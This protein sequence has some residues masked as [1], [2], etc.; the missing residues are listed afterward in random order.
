LFPQGAQTALAVR[1]LT[2]SKESVT[3]GRS[4][5]RGPDLTAP[6][7]ESLPEAWLRES[8]KARTVT[9]AKGPKIN[10]EKDTFAARLSFMKGAGP[11]MVKSRTIRRRR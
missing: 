11:A 9:P 10:R 1:Q 4:A 2:E 3:D 7:E 5:A 8:M 6:S